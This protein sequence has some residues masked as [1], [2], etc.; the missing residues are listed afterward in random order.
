[1]KNAYRAYK[2]LYYTILDAIC[3]HLLLKEFEQES[4]EDPIPLPDH[5]DQFSDAEKIIWINDIC[6]RIIDKYFFESSPDIMSKLRDCVTD[7]NHP[8]NYWVSNFIDG[9]VKCHHCE[10]TYA[11]VGSL[12]VHEEKLHGVSVS[13]KQRKDKG[14]SKDELYGYM[15]QLFKLTILHKNLDDAVDMADGA[16]SI[17]SAKY[18]LPI[19]NFTN[20]TKY[21]IG[22]IHL[23]AMTEGLL[24]KELKERLTANRFINLQGGKNNNMALDE[25]VELLNRD[26]KIAC[27]G[28]QTKQSI[29]AH[30]KE[31]PHIIKSTKHFDAICEV[32]GRKGCH[33]VPS[34]FEDVQKVVKEL[35]EINAFSVVE[36]RK[37]KCRFLQNN[38]KIYDDCLK[39]LST[40]IVR[41]KPAVAYH[42]L[43]NK[44]I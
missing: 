12:K 26:S 34:Y 8:D 18:E 38:Q 5:I 28:F 10:K 20:K 2:Y 11:Y 42:R 6:E 21:A 37:L 17:K 39:G 4:L 31:F 22:S 35:V 30:S 9:R 29:I 1:M 13:K 33:T 24:N 44:H 32:T 7:K 23:I 27:S 43:R 19:Y 41:H 16:R 36:G 15:L 14:K 25:Y 40:L 3:C